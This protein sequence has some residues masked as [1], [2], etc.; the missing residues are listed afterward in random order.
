MGVL[1]SG[2]A[3]YIG[4]HVVLALLDHGFSPIILDDL[5]TGCRSL[6]PQNVP[7]VIG[8]IGNR[9][10][11]AEVIR[12]NEIDIIFHFAGKIIVSESVSSPLA[13]YQSNTVNSHSLIQVAVENGV[14]NFVFSSTATVYD[15]SNLSR[16]EETAA[17]A[18]ISPYGASKLMAERM[19]RDASAAHNLNY[20]ILR[21]F[22][23]AGAD[24]RMRRGQA[25]RDATH[26]VK[27]A[28]AAAMEDEP[29]IQIFGDDYPTPDGTC[30]R[31]YIHVSDLADAHVIALK[32]VRSHGS[33]ILNCGYGKGHSV[34]DVL[35]IVEKVTGRTLEKRIAGRREG[36]PPSLVSDNGRLLAL[37][38]K[39]QFDDLFTIIQHA[40]QWEKLLRQRN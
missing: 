1:V 14:R 5:S 24:P 12:K 2:G 38:W 31:D 8:D 28:L 6:V 39:P 40:Y 16:I 13:Y 25:G 22:N 35:E 20:A 11:V 4:G 33:I 36:D 27:V 3:G 17:L 9:E 37:G 7:L 21:Y 19:L 23:V 34:K 32:H 29:S 15:Q 18:P 30:I 10:L 26:L